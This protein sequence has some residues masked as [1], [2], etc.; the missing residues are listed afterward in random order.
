MGEQLG[1]T[2]RGVTDPVA[3]VTGNIPIVSGLTMGPG[4]D[5]LPLDQQI[6]RLVSTYAVARFAPGSLPQ[7][8][9]S[10]AQQSSNAQAPFLDAGFQERVSALTKGG[11]AQREAIKQ[12]MRE[13]NISGVLPP[14]ALPTLS[15]KE[16]M[17]SRGAQAELGESY[18]LEDEVAKAKEA[19]Q[20]TLLPLANFYA[21]HGLTMTPAM[22]AAREG[23]LGVAGQATGVFTPGL[24]VQGGKLSGQ[25]REPLYA[26]EPGTGPVP[27]TP[28]VEGAATETRVPPGQPVGTLEPGLGII[29]DGKV[30]TPAGVDENG[31]VLLREMSP[32]EQAKA[33]EDVRKGRIK[34]KEEANKAVQSSAGKL[35]EVKVMQMQL[36]SA[37]GYDLDA[38]TWKHQ[39]VFG[40]PSSSLYSTNQWLKSLSRRSTGEPTMVSGLARDFGGK[41]MQ[42]TATY[43]DVL[44]GPLAT[45]IA[46]AAGEV[47]PTDVD[48]QRMVNSAGGILDQP[49]TAVA[50]LKKLPQI[51]A[52]QALL[53]KN[54]YREQFGTDPAGGMSREQLEG[55]ANGSAQWPM[56]ESGTGSTSSKVKGLSNAELKRL[57]REGR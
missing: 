23:A 11:M 20:P 52:Q 12:A 44:H 7:L 10:Y 32:Q 54:Q 55:I 49:D 1:Q 37:M 39:M 38:D 6:A 33:A 50:K 17:E 8:Y 41:E 24:Q 42:A 16:Q 14:S 13:F 15:A 9:G 56:A 4:A 18:R 29:R 53:L 26:A 25:V 47:R 5:M 57:A 43:L 48:V 19:G 2:W 45:M 3:R 22:Q 46:K 51:A 27:G 30:M 31:E 35:S 34:A 21:A 36:A 40:D 28:Q